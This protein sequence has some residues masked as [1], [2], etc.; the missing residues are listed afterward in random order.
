MSKRPDRAPSSVQ[1]PPMPEALPNAPY[2]YQQ[3][4]AGMSSINGCA[5][6]KR[7]AGDLLRGFSLVCRA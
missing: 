3:D 5:G 4:S 7:E 1:M 6:P 2:R